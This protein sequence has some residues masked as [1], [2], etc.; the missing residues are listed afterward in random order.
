MGSGAY[1]EDLQRLEAQLA[2]ISARRIVGIGRPARLAALHMTAGAVSVRNRYLRSRALLLD[3]ALRAYNSAIRAR[4]DAWL[5]EALGIPEWR[6]ES[7]I[8]AFGKE[9]LLL[10]GFAHD[11]IELAPEDWGVLAVEPSVT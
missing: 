6:P 9:S 10:M 4:L 8:V 3:H 2:N 11:E 1:E 7:A 5:S